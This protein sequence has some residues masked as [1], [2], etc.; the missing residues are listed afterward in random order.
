MSSSPSFSLSSWHK[1]SICC[2]STPLALPRLA[3]SCT[4]SVHV[5]TIPFTMLS[6]CWLGSS[7]QKVCKTQLRTLISCFFS[8][9]HNRYFLTKCQV[10]VSVSG[11][12]EMLTSRAMALGGKDQAVR[13][14]GL[15]TNSANSHWPHYWGMS[16]V[17][18]TACHNGLIWGSCQWE[19]DITPLEFAV[20]DFAVKWN[21]SHKGLPFCLSWLCLNIS[22][23]PERIRADLL[24]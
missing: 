21:P 22:D 2:G 12:R 11:K 16:A 17:T 5:H 4:G 18:A 15:E 10:P 23:L 9:L 8:H 13:K 7:L 14:A 6:Q 24:L 19:I 20:V 1:Q 3:H